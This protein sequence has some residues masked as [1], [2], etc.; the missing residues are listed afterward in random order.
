MIMKPDSTWVE[1][2][3][4]DPFKELM[5]NPSDWSTTRNAI[6]YF[7]YPSW[8]LYDKFSD[9][10]LTSYFTQLNSWDLNFDLGV[11]AIKDHPYATTGEQCYN[12]ASTRWARFGSLGADIA[13]LTIDEP[14]T[15]TIRG[16][17]PKQ[18]FQLFQNKNMPFEKLQTG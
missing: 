2:C 5:E 8:I 12:I 13:S 3:S 15:A 14:F 6:D 4:G 11:I 9:S 17:L 18:L 10:L 16:E 1:R 7:G